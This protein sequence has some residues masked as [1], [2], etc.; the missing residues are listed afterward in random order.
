[1]KD[2]RNV[3]EEGVKVYKGCQWRNYTKKSSSVTNA[4]ETMDNAIVAVS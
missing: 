1:M 2:E 3:V 4:R